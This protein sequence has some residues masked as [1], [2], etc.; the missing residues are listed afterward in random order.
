MSLWVAAGYDQ[1][2]TTEMIND[3]REQLSHPNYH[4]AL[5]VPG[6]FDGYNEWLDAIAGLKTLTIEQAMAKLTRNFQA[7]VLS[8][9]VSTCCT[10]VHIRH[11]QSAYRTGVMTR[12]YFAAMRLSL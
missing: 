8:R 2:D 11:T 10:H 9:L 3:F 6:A 7:L 4:V 12:Y 5:R 1:N